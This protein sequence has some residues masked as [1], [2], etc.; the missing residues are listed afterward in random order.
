MKV[1]VKP[2]LFLRDLL[3]FGAREIE[4]PDR[5]VKTAGE[6]LEILRSEFK[7]PDRLDLPQGRLVL[8]EGNHPAGLI[9]LIN[10]RNIGRLK[11]LETALSEGDLISLFPPAAGG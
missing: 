1:T 3:G 2:Y 7:L 4:L 11:G 5:G 6:L 10:G 8:F 9:I